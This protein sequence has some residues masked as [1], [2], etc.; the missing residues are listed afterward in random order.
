MK[1]NNGLII[2]K[3]KPSLGAKNL[4]IIPNAN[5]DNGANKTIDERNAKI[6]LI[7]NKEII[8]GLLMPRQSNMALCFL[9]RK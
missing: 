7:E 1:F 4:L 6:E 3:S 2:R 9:F 5:N 8:L